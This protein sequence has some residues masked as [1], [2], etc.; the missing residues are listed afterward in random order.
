VPR[1]GRWTRGN[2][3]NR[4]VAL[5]E[6]GEKLAKR[7]GGNSSGSSITGPFKKKKKRK[8]RKK[9]LW[10]EN[11]KGPQGTPQKR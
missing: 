4:H 6:G 10:E 3:N 11:I 1:E 2:G 8:S 5:K 7:E 9:A